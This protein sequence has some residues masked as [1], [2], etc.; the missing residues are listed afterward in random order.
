MSLCKPGLALAAVA[1]LL[2]CGSAVAAPATT[3][4]P[5]DKESEC[6]WWLSADDGKSH[7][8]SIGQ[9]YDG[10]VLSVSAPAFKTWSESDLHKVELRF[11]K[12][13]KRKMV[14]EGWVSLGGGHAQ[15]LGVFLD[16]AGMKAMDRAT[17]LEVRRG[18]VLAAELPLAATPTEAEL[19]GCII[20]PS[21]EHS[22]SE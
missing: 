3:V 10:V 11:N 15:M 4:K 2:G 17:L 22:D 13:P 19:K 1:A 6:R 5:W 21:S 7:Q 8:A 9:T 12:D 16:A 20:P 14:G 18:G